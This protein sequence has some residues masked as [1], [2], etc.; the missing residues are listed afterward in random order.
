MS[1]IHEVSP[2]HWFEPLMACT[3]LNTNLLKAEL[4]FPMLRSTPTVLGL[5]SEKVVQPKEELW[6]WI[7]SLECG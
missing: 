5:A 1:S 6:F 3:K 4:V 7:V 2:H